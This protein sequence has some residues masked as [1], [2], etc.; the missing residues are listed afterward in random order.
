[1]RIENMRVQ[2]L[3]QPLG[4]GT[5]QPIFSYFLISDGKHWQSAFRIL[6]ASTKELLEQEIGDLWDSGVCRQKETFGIVYQGK[7]LQSRQRVYW[8][9]IVWDENENCI[10]YSDISF[11]EMGLLEQED[12]QGKW[13]GQGD[14]YDGDKSH[15]PLLIK[16]FV[17]KNEKKIEKARLYIS[18]LGLF[19]AELNGQKLSDTL[20]DPGECDATKTVYYVVYDV[21]PNLQEETNV[22]LVTLGNGQY[23]NFQVNPVMALPDGTLLKPHR[24]Q[25]NDGAFIKPG[26]SGDKKLIAQ[27]EVTYD[28]GERELVCVSDESWKWTKGPIVFQNWY[29]GEDYDATLEWQDMQCCWESV[30]SMKPPAGRLTAREFYPIRIVKRISPRKIQKLP[31]GK[32]LVDM[33]RNGAGFPEIHI[34]TTKEMRGKWIK[35]YPAEMLKADGSGVNQ[36]S[37]TQSWNERFQCVIQDGYRIKGT[38]REVWHPIFCYQGFQYLEVEGW[39]GELKKENL[40]YCMVRTDNEKFGQFRTSN[41]VLNQI[42]SMIEHS[43]ESNMFFAFTDCPQIEKL[44]WIETS[45]LMF[46]SLADCYDIYAW[47]KKLYMIL[48]ILKW[49]NGR[50]PLREMSR[51]DMYR[52]LFRSFNEL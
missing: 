32:W 2:G 25:K 41:P 28:T 45:H 1:M 6:V 12:W 46:T 22:L 36:A 51:R 47:M 30:K 26:I 40:S 33:G 52:L 16:Q 31:N 3:C 34:D 20:F 15:A 43:M 13:I 50:P 21:T 37:C 44:G 9:V 8:R 48:P 38:G 49:I 23:T 27:L 17:I 4:L 10:G 29:G 5:K 18:G 24:Y 35:L 11:W 7:E 42:S 39:Q 14:D 19:Q